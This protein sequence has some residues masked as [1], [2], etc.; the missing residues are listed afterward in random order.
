MCR[1]HTI[2]TCYYRTFWL[3]LF[4]NL[5]LEL[6]ITEFLKCKILNTELFFFEDYSNNSIQEIV[7]FYQALTQFRKINFL[8]D[9]TFHFKRLGKFENRPLK[10]IIKKRSYSNHSKIT[11]HFG[12]K[13]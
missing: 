5:L 9:R 2:S 10:K 11:H 7:N 12:C 13:R 6:F 1:I 8:H 4:H 3:H